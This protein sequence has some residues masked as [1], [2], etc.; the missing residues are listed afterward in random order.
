MRWFTEPTKVTDKFEK[1]TKKIE[2]FTQKINKVTQ[3]PQEEEEDSS[4]DTYV[5]ELGIPTVRD[6]IDVEDGW[7][8]A[9]FN[10][11][12]ATEIMTKIKTGVD[13]TSGSKTWISTLGYLF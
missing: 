6:Y 9:V 11:M 5:Y 8:E 7:K 1:L 12:W 3:P 2:E 4:N 13:V 10:L